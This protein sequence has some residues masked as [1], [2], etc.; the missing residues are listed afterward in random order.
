MRP[1]S[2]LLAELPPA[3]LLAFADITLEHWS[4]P[5]FAALFL[6]G[7]LGVLFMDGLRR[8]RQWG[9]LHPWSSGRRR[10]T[11]PTATRGARR[12]A[13]VAL[14]AALLVPGVLPGYERAGLLRLDTGPLSS[15]PVINPL[16]SVTAILHL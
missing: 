12:L 15:S 13:A 2:P 11:S 7:A 8:V 9:P 5:L 3:S 4:R 14:G 6:I 10:L 1:R 16:V